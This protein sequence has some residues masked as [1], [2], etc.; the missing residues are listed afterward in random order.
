MYF[1]FWEK[2][3]QQVHGIYLVQWPWT[4]DDSLTVISEN[5]IKEGRKS[6]G[7]TIKANFGKKIYEAII[8]QIGK[9][10]VVAFSP[11][12]PFYYH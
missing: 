12:S 8:L 11:F 2:W 3:H 9:H 6:A 10:V 5:A 4:T 1:T 7:E